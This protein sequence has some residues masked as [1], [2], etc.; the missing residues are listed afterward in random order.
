LRATGDGVIIDFPDKNPSP[1]PATKLRRRSRNKNSTSY[2]PQI[3]N[4]PDEYKTDNLAQMNLEDLINLQLQNPQLKHEIRL[5]HEKD[6]EI[7]KEINLLHRYREKP[8]LFWRD[9]LGIPI[10]KWADDKPPISWQEGDSVPLW[11]KQRQIIEALVKYRKVAVKS[12]HG[13]GKSFIAAGTALYLALVWHATGMTTA[14]TFRQVR[15]ILWGEIHYLYNKAVNPL[16]G[17][18]N[19]I[20]LDLGDKWFVEGFATDKPESNITGIHE[21]NIFVIVDEAGG[22][23]EEVFDAL[24]AL[25]TSESTFVLYIGNPIVSEG[26]FFDAFKPGSGFFTMS[27][28]C[29]DSP[30]VKYQRNIYPKLTSHKWVADKEKRWGKNS[31]LFKSRVEGEF[32]EENS[33]SLIPLKYLN[34]ALLKGEEETDRKKIVSY[35]ADIARKGTDAT[36][37]GR[38]YA[39]GIYEIADIINQAMTTEVAGRMKSIYDT[40]N[41]KFKDY[42]KTSMIPKTQRDKEKEKE[43]EQSFPQINVDDIGVGGGVTDILDEDNYPVVGINVGESPDESLEDSELFLNKRAQYYWRLRV[44]FENNEVALVDEETAFELSKI[45]AEYLRT[46]KIKIVDKDLIK[47]EL[48]G[49]SPDRAESMMLAWASQDGDFDKDWVR[50]V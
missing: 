49:R 25:L 35:G 13:V 15:R 44:A 43:P 3:L 27:L 14:P 26:R 34:R 40:D 16:G 1:P 48:N 22:V 36:V 30:N 46:G 7:K 50:F 17:R 5:Q 10:F 42:L 4:L 20:S 28:S 19:Q 32:P 45:R 39:S 23:K 24:D 9:E 31:I 29:Y 21:E 12:G 47:K 8:L 2:S 18:L 41:P 38:R 6:D 37:I 33:D 11:S